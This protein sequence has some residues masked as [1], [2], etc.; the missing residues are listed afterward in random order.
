MLDGLLTKGR[1]LHAQTSC[2]IRWRSI[3]ILGMLVNIIALPKSSLVTCQG[4][5]AGSTAVDR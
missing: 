2:V 5:G 3:H 1:E 4:L